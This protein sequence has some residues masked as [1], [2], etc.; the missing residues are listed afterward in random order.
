[1]Y[2]ITHTYENDIKYKSL[3]NILGFSSSFTSLRYEL[4]GQAGSDMSPWL[5]VYIEY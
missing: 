2:L 3:R 5:M 1:M 4:G